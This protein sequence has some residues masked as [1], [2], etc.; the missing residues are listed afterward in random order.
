MLLPPSGR[1]AW[2][3][4]TCI[5]EEKHNI[6]TLDQR[7]YYTLWHNVTNVSSKCLSMTHSLYISN[8]GSPSYTPAHA[9]STNQPLSVW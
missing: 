3:M 9:N 6:Y 4:S 8:T 2:C 5:G 1:T 7:L